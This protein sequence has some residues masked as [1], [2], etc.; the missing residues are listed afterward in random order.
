MHLPRGHD[1]QV[2]PRLAERVLE[3]ERV[4]VELGLNGGEIGQIGAEERALP[5]VCRLDPRFHVADPQRQSRRFVNQGFRVR[6]IRPRAHGR[7]QIGEP[8]APER[9]DA[10]A[11][12]RQRGR[13]AG[14]CGEPSL[15]DA[16]EQ[17]ASRRLLMERQAL[18]GGAPHAGLGAAHADVDRTLVRRRERPEAE[19]TRLEADGCLAERVR[20]LDDAAGLRVGGLEVAALDG[21]VGEP[22]PRLG[23]AGRMPNLRRDLQHRVKSRPRLIQ[24]TLVE[25]HAAD[26]LLSDAA[27]ILKPRFER[28]RLCLITLAGAL[29]IAARQRDVGQAEPRERFR[30]LL[31]DRGGHP[32]AGF[33]A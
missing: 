31:D 3:Q 25:I 9:A 15:E 29:A 30:I 20:D 22:C 10:G 16:I 28:R 19:R 27:I 12:R 17:A 32:Q 21:E 24:P 7:L 5:C 1:P 11:L 6:R 2:A 13:H 23:F 18:L 4:V 33:E 14:M 8:C 26:A